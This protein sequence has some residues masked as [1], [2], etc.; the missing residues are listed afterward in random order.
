M[1]Y[2]CLGPFKIFSFIVIV[3][4]IQCVSKVLYNTEEKNKITL[5]SSFYIRTPSREA[6]GVCEVTEDREGRASAGEEGP[7]HCEA[8]WSQQSPGRDPHLPRC[9]LYVCHYSLIMTCP[10]HSNYLTQH[11]SFC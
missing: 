9:S 2:N 4:F 10:A 3:L 1:H 8:S 11:S 5:M 6:G 7:Y